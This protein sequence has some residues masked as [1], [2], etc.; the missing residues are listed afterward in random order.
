MKL[1]QQCPKILRKRLV[2]IVLINNR[3]DRNLMQ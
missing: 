3:N 1:E 2:L